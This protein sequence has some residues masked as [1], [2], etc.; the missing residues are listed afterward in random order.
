MVHTPTT[1]I[2]IL[3]S[4]NLSLT[5]IYFLQISLKDWFLSRDGVFSLVPVTASF[6]KAQEFLK[7]YGRLLV[8]SDNEE[9]LIED[10][11][12]LDDDA[13]RDLWELIK[14]FPYPTRERQ[15]LP[16]DH[17]DAIRAIHGDIQI[18]EKENSI[19]D[20][21][22]LKENG[23]CVDNIVP[24]MSNIPHAG[25]G[26]FA[27]RFIPKGGLVHPAPVVHI[28]DKSAVNM[29]NET[30]GNTTG[31]MVRDEKVGVVQK[32]IIY[33]YMFGHPNSTV[34]LFPYSSN[35]A[36]INHH[37][38]EYNA[39]LRWAKDFS[40]F[41]HEDW[42]EKDVEF[43]ENQWTSGLM[44]EF[45]ALRDIQVGEEVRDYVSYVCMLSHWYSSI[46]SLY[47]ISRL[48]SSSIMV[49]SGNRHGMNTSKTGNHLHQKVILAI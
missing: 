3:F 2:N 40:F 14:T 48:R 5:H 24:G 21:K 42:L 17:K 36:Y 39:E 15:A 4:P 37:A 8:G 34:L 10:K 32:Q 16:D 43:L 33:N 31:K 19:R 45:I 30:I 26:A 49:R 20:M 18:I 46:L 12:A 7:V 23:K 13:Q 27:T 25:R 41:H 1:H 47:T 22:Y 38:T 29:Y 11:M 9:D 6:E 44:L 28:T 35:A